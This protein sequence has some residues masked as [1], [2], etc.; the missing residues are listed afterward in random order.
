MFIDRGRNQRRPQSEWPK[1]SVPSGGPCQSAKTRD[2]L[3]R[4]GPP[5]GG[6][7]RLVTAFYK[8]GPAMWVSSLWFW[9]SDFLLV[10]EDMKPVVEAVETVG[11]V[12]NSERNGVDWRVFHGF[13]S[14]HSLHYLYHHRGW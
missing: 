10:F 6:R 11:T 12:G 7:P 9:R 3:Y 14:F 4:H 1:P 13:H 5:G 8:H 2:A